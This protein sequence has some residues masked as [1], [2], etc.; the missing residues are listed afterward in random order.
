[1]CSGAGGLLPLRSADMVY[2]SLGCSPSA[3]TMFRA[4][5]RIVLSASILVP[6]AGWSDSFLTTVTF[7]G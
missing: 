4:T 2:K 1:M 5:V 7:S 6:G 3:K